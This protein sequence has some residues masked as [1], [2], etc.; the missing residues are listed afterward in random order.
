MSHD[1][2][3]KSV[4]AA[5]ADKYGPAGFKWKELRYKIRQ[6]SHFRGDMAVRPRRESLREEEDQAQKGG[7]LSQY[8]DTLQSGSRNQT[9]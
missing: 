5:G 8:V 3:N 7:L 4:S 9:Y 6:G 1:R 2:W